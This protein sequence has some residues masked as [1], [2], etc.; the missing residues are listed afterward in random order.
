MKPL[1]YNFEAYKKM[2]KYDLNKPRIHVIEG[3]R[4]EHAL[5]SW[6]VQR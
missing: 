1:K 2:K 3:K 6:L 4:L 5:A